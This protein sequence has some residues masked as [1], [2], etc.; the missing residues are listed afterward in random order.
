MN[1]REFCFGVDSR[2]NKNHPFRYAYYRAF[3]LTTWLPFGPST[4]SG[5]SE[6]SLRGGAAGI[7]RV[8]ERNRRFVGERRRDRLRHDKPFFSSSL[9]AMVLLVRLGDLTTDCSGASRQQRSLRSYCLPDGAEG[10]CQ[11]AELSRS[12]GSSLEMATPVS[13]RSGEWQQLW[14][15][16]LTGQTRCGAPRRGLR[17]W[18]RQ[19]GPR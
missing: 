5:T 9:P 13:D 12:R 15:V 10:S 3:V 6:A 14:L 18:G 17:D 4:G 2:E 7:G 8:G 11:G 16:R 1:T 19:R